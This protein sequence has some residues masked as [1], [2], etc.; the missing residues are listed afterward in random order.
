MPADYVEYS[1]GG[2]SIAVRVR[3]LFQMR[4]ERCVSEKFPR[5]SHYR[6]DI[7]AD[8][9]DKSGLHAFRAFGHFSHHDYGLFERRRFFLNPT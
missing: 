8:D 2:L 9:F 4:M 6:V 3:Y 5:R 1:P 7:G